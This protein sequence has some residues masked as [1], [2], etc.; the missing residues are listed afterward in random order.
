MVVSLQHEYRLVR[1]MNGVLAAETTSK[2]VR[3]REEGAGSRCCT[4][5]T[6]ARSHPS[7]SLGAG[8]HKKDAFASLLL[9]KEEQGEGQ[10]EH[11]HGRD[12]NREQYEEREKNTGQK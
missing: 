3:E 10:R 4:T 9:E 12:G 11:E 8:G 2:K 6:L 7:F 5:G 1:P